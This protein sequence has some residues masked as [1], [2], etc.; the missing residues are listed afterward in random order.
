MSVVEIYQDGFKQAFGGV[1]SSTELSTRR[2]FD[3]SRLRDGAGGA[4]LARGGRRV[5][6]DAQHA[7]QWLGGAPQQLI[8]D[9]EG[10]QVFT[11]HRELPQPADRNVER[12][13]DGS[14]CE[15]GEAGFLLVRHH[16]YPLVR[17]AEN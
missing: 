10:R 8:P 16:G 13:G 1:L 7:T 5:E 12:A 11:T 4:R 14:R 6:D 2:I 17:R 15:L 9:G 3:G